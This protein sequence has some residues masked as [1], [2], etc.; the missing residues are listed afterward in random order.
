[1]NSFSKIM[2]GLMLLFLTV[3]VLGVPGY[4]SAESITRTRALNTPGI[5]IGPNPQSLGTIQIAEFSIASLTPTINGERPLQIAV[6]LPPGSTYASVPAPGDESS[7]FDIPE[8][9]GLTPNGLK[10]GDVK[11]DSA[12]T[13]SKLI[14]NIITRS[15]FLDQAI[16][17]V[18]FD[19]PHSQVVVLSADKKYEVAITQM[20]NLPDVNVINTYESDKIVNA[21]VGEGYV[22]AQAVEAPDITP[23]IGR[24]PAEITLV[25][26]VPGALQ[27]SSRA[28]SFTLPQGF[29][30]TWAKIKQS[31][32][33]LSGDISIDPK[34]GIDLDE[35]GRSRLW[36]DINHP[37]LNLPWPMDPQHTTKGEP[38]IIKIQGFFNV[39]PTAQP[40]QVVVNIGGTNQDINPK[41]MVIAN[42]SGS[43]ASSTSSKTSTFI[44]GEGVFNLNGMDVVMETAPYINQ[45]RTFLPLRYVAYALGVADSGI[46]WDGAGQTATLVK[47][48]QEIKLTIN[49]NIIK[50][51]GRNAGY[52]DAVPE[53][54][55]GLT[56]L[57]VGIIAETLGGEVLWDPARQE[58]KVIYPKTS[59]ISIN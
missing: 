46:M 9:A 25:E 2:G 35:T 55:N 58:V 18:R 48:D 24:V 10:P 11:I 1:M 15:N 5:T 17:N 34:K 52:L 21:Y 45:G 42:L 59:S 33:F 41:S 8:T 12:S 4:A 36:L 32:G 19:M 30:W 57:P 27:A 47:G 20:R 51:N 7:Y 56:M 16:I 38:G 3:S 40:G 29:T 49:S 22:T 23:G 14:M 39:S 26:N 6:S 44:I 37:S 13:S 31:G 28:V 53:I 43:E 50:V 54:R